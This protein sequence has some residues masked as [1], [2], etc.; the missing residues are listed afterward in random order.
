MNPGHSLWI[1]VDSSIPT[2]NTVS[3]LSCKA[4]GRDHTR[5]CLYYSNAHLDTAG[6]MVAAVSLQARGISP[7]D[8]E[9]NDQP[10]WI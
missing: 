3:E 6:C 10:Y 7:S 1:D 4:P 9:N 5:T 8:L 2:H